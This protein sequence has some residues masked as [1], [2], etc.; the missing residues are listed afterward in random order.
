MTKK[1]LLSVLSKLNNKKM[2]LVFKRDW[3]VTCYYHIKSSFDM[4]FASLLLKIKR[5]CVRSVRSKLRNTIIF[6]GYGVAMHTHLIKSTFD[7][8]FTSL[9]LEIT[10]SCELRTLHT[11][12]QQNNYDFQ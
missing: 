8:I 12:K 4:I 5:I 1:C 7:M 9:L 3:I 2:I 11:K 10:K 6:N